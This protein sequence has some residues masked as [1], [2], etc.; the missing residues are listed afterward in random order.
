MVVDDMIGQSL[1]NKNGNNEEGLEKSVHSQNN[2]AVDGRKS[3]AWETKMEIRTRKHP[4]LI[5]LDTCNIT[6]VPT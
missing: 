5:I 6:M 3:I 4:K 1:D 2:M